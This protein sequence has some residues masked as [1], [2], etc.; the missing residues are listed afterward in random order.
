MKFRKTALVPILLMVILTVSAC[1]IGNQ[2]E[3]IHKTESSLKVLYYSPDSFQMEYGMLLTALYPHIDITVVGLNMIERSDSSGEEFDYDTA[4]FDLVEREKPDILLL[5]PEQFEKLAHEHKLY[6]LDPLIKQ[7]NY[8][9]EGLVPNL[10]EYLREVGHGQLYGLANSFTSRALYYNKDLF[11]QYQIPY[12]T[13]QMSW[14]DLLQLAMRFPTGGHDD[15]RIYGLRI[16]ES[17]DLFELASWI[18]YIEGLSF[19]DS[20]AKQANMKSDSWRN[21]FQQ[22]WDAIRYG[23]LYAISGPAGEL[24]SKNTSTST[25]STGFEVVIL[26]LQNSDPF[27]AGKIAMTLEPNSIVYQIKQAQQKYMSDDATIK[28]WDMVTIPVS[29][30]GVGRNPHMMMNQI[31]A[32]HVDSPNKDAAWEV[33]SYITGDDYARVKSKAAT[34]GLSMRTAYLRDEEGHNYE[35]FY[36]LEPDVSF[37]I[38]GDPEHLP[39]NF[40]RLFRNEARS[41]FERVMKQEVSLEEALTYMEQWANLNLQAD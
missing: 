33:L 38:Y 16:S 24:V 14:E 5:D 21:V 9:L 18:G 28:N 8:D 39:Q 30:Q 41:V 40:I 11:D 19:I 2:K 27:I 4:V 23:S 29:K 7:T 12:P 6:N 37:N 25:S 26:E 1:S 3:E 36:R 35:A 34:G 17:R 20:A 32:I 15:E 31:F 22:A 10:L 13:D